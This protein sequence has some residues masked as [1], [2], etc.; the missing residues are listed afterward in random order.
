MKTP[1]QSAW[2]AA[3]VMGAA[4]VG[5]ALSGCTTDPPT[6]PKP[7]SAGPCLDKESCGDLPYF[8]P[9]GTQPGGTTTVLPRIPP[10]CRKDR[11]ADPDYLG[12]EIAGVGESVHSEP[13]GG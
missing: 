13:A 7:Q 9:W 11:R 6:A 8:D 12:P 1:T 10:L 4:L 5:A 3:L 2:L